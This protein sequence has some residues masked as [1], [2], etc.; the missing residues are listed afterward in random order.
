[1]PCRRGG[2]PSTGRRAASRPPA[3]AA[4]ARFPLSGLDAG[5]GAAVTF[6]D[7]AGTSV[8]ATAAADGTYTVDLSGLTG[9]VTSAIVVT[10]V[11]G[12]SG[13]GGGN[14]IVIEGDTTTPPQTP[15]PTIGG[16]QEDTGTPGDGI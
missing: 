16:I 9:T 10:D 13:V 8:A 15:A 4:V 14:A 7:G 6:T 12:N 11:A 5:S 3:E 2:S 1:M